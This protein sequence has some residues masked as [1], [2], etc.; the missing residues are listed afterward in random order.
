MITSKAAM[1]RSSSE[2][3]WV[4]NTDRSPWLIDERAAELLLGQGPE[5]QAD[6]AGCDRHIEHTHAEAQNADDPQNDQVGHVVVQRVGAHRGEHEDAGIEPGLGDVQQL[7]PDAGHG[8]VEHQQQHV[9][10]VEAGDQAP[11]QV[12]AAVEQQRAGL[13]AV[14]LERR[15]QDGGS[16]RGRQ[17]EREQGRQRAGHG[18]VVRGLGAGHGFDRT[19]AELLRVL[20]Q[21]LLDQI[22]EEGRNLAAASRQGADRKAQER[23]AQ[24]G[25]PGSRPVLRDSSRSSRPGVDLLLLELVPGGRVESLADRE[26]ADGDDDSVDAVEQFHDPQGETRLAGLQIDAD[27]PKR[28]TDEQA[29]QAARPDCRRARR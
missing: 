28:Q 11:D 12:G 3:G 20:G 16:G 2:I 5:D 15:E 1:H 7:H 13:Q 23:A 4:K 21:A 6:H 9:A 22:G 26:Q 14:L 24:P 25:L 19:L 8:Q 27:K 10:D 18:R 17:A 29:G